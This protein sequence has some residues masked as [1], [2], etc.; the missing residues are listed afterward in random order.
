[1]T[2][3]T[4]RAPA[5]SE[6]TFLGDPVESEPPRQG[7]WSRRAPLIAMAAVFISFFALY[8]AIGYHVVVDLHLVNFDSLSRLSHAYFIWWNDPPK[9][10][11]IGFIWPPMQTLVYLPVS[12]IKPL[13]VS[14]AAIPMVSAFFMAGT[15]LVLDRTLALTEVRWFARWP[16]VLVLGLNPMIVWYGANGLGEA[17]YLFFLTAGVYFLV[18]W[19]M[20]RRTHLLA[21]VGLAIG[22]GIL[23]RYEIIPF[24]IVIGAGIATLVGGSRRARASQELEGSLLLYL[25]PVAYAGAAWM[26]FN[27]LIIGDPISFL[28]ISP[29]E[30]DIGA[31]AQSTTAIV[32]PGHDLATTVEQVLAL[33]IGLFPLAILVV[34]PLLLTAALKRDLMS[35]ILVALLGTNAVVTAALFLDSGESN[36]LQLRY[37]MRAIP[38]ALMGVGW[39]YYMW[40]PKPMRAAIVVATLAI[41]LASLAGTW[42]MM[43]TYPFQGEENLFLAALTSGESQEG[44]ISI[45][46]FPNGIG[47]EQEIADWVDANVADDEHVLTD[48]AQTFGILL[49]SGHPERFFDRID[50]GDERWQAALD[51]PFGTVDYLLIST[52]KRCPS[53]CVDLVRERYPDLSTSDPEAGFTV[54][55]RTK[56]YL[57]L[58]VAEMPPDVDGRLPSGSP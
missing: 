24:A 6:P 37:N 35:L 26:F 12:L 41:L 15:I 14:L 32:P 49:L 36:L 22:F 19:S 27:W 17:V 11:A 54:V 40:R 31:P 4:T 33:N 43:Q 3:A 29:T 58:E 53:P 21:M 34:P 8:F 46:G 48:D 57:L 39:L 47:D 50:K 42:R 9:L 51:A 16:L 52:D 1:M 45:S 56:R 5:R 13:A 55:L 10:A 18:R 23:S 7:W 44:N 30:A 25:A 28:A 20:V 38:L 2:V